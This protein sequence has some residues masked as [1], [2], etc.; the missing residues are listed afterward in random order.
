MGGMKT[1]AIA[2]TLVTFIALAARAWAADDPMMGTWKLNEAKSKIAPGAPKN[3]TVVYAAAGDQV[4]ITVDGTDAQGKTI[5]SEWTGKFDGKD[6]PVTGDA[7][8]D[9]RSYKKA[10]KDTLEMANK[11]GGKVT[12]TGEVLVSDD[13]KSRTVT[14]SFTDDKGAKVKSTAV[15]DKS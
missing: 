1:K 11:K 10:G 14:I 13:G 2:F 6:Y 7:N 15:Y 4:K 12:V 8:A 5:H 3:H 9:M